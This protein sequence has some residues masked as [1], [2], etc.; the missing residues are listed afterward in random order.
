MVGTFLTDYS[1]WG[2][3]KNI[4]YSTPI[5]GNNDAEKMQHLKDK[6]RDAFAS[7]SLAMLG[8]LEI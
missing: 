2:H 5:V 1:L 3:V 8:K 4:V 6:I 7:I